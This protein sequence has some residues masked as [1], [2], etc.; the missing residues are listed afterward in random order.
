MNLNRALKLSRKFTAILLN[1]WRPTALTG[2]FIGPR[3]II[4]SVPK[5]GTNLVQEILHQFPRL[6]GRVMKT[7]TSEMSEDALL[8]KIASIRRG[9]VMPAH[10]FFDEKISR[11]MCERNIKMIFVVRDFRDAMLSHINYIDQI[12]ISHP[13]HRVFSELKNM[14]EK[15]DAC[16][17]GVK[18]K[19]Q[20]WPNLVRGFRGWVN[21]KNVML[22]HFEDLIGEYGGGSKEAQRAVV[23]EMAEFLGLKLPD[24]QKVIQ[25]MYNK[26]GLTFN[27]P[28]IGKWKRKFNQ[29]QIERINSFL[30]DDIQ[31][32]SHK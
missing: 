25:N 3:V 6:R 20:S 24:V 11:L 10:I 26:N 31:Y 16:L 23:L 18:D 30:L 17:L 29:H 32:F 12:D 21:S 13:H 8:D 5:S 4:N 28:E 7:I 15:I 2:R 22:V 1:G 19:F 9:E 14:D 27:A